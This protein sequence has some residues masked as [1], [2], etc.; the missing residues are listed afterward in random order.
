VKTS[1]KRTT[2]EDARRNRT[3]SRRKEKSIGKTDDSPLSLRGKT[4][5]LAE[6]PIILCGSKSRPADDEGKAIG[7]KKRALSKE[8]GKNWLLGGKGN[9]STNGG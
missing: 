1:K 7:G 4:V 9:P 3:D 8:K 6:V 5:V 2:T